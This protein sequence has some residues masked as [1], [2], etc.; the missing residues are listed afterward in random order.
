M[1][2]IKTEIKSGGKTVEDFTKWIRVKKIDRDVASKKS[3]GIKGYNS[4]ESNR[5]QKRH[6]DAIDDMLR[7]ILLYN[8][9]VQL[10]KAQQ[11]LHTW[12]IR[13]MTGIQVAN[14]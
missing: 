14:Q 7:M 5:V 13:T 1:E 12:L 11:D 6:F 10:L 2:V 3:Y 4:E 8:Q 9:Q